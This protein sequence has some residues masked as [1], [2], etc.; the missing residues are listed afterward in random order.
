MDS[1]LSLYGML[2]WMHKDSS[3]NDCKY[4][5][6]L[7]LLHQSKFVALIHSVMEV[8]VRVAVERFSLSLN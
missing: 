5:Q 4:A 3:V 2:P 8:T 7:V 1:G 6:V